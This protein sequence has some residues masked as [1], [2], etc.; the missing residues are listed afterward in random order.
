MK[1]WQRFFYKEIIFTFLFLLGCIYSLYII[2]DLMAHVKD[3]REGHT[4]LKTWFIFY[5]CTLSKRLDVLLP[6]VVLIGSIR[7]LLHFRT[8]NII[9]ALLAGGV[10]LKKLLQPF[11][12]VCLAVSSLLYIN[13]Q[14]ILPKAQPRAQFILESNFSN[15]KY[16]KDSPSFHEF[17]LDDGSK[18]LYR[19]YDPEEMIFHD[20]F[21]IAT[22]D[23]IYHMKTLM[24]QMQVASGKMVDVIQ[25]MPSGHMQKEGSFVQLPFPEI[26]FDEESLKRSISSL[27]DQGLTDL[28]SQLQSSGVDSEKSYEAY[29]TLLF[30]LTYPLLPLLA[31][32]SIAPF[33]IGF[34][35]T[36]APFMTYLIAICTL[37]CFLIILQALLVL[38]KGHSI[39]AVI[40]CVAPWIITFTLAGRRYA[41]TT[42]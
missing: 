21:W 34:T 2:L 15:K 23:T 27:K 31:F 16:V 11:I 14:Y 37:F 26:H 3:L 41:K 29:A 39:P 20:V 35:R 7:V 30:K 17:S 1:I 4:T 24:C 10:S 18:L 38:S 13:Y 28:F 5:L 36:S 42:Q 19:A 33:C 32:V 8:Q 22:T 6:F 25:R 9:I 40:G 12:V